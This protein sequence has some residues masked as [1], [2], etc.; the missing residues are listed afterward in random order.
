MKSSVIFALLVFTTLSWSAVQEKNVDFT[1]SPA[2]MLDGEIQYA[3]DWLSPD[4]LVNR[5]LRVITG[6]PIAAKKPSNTQ[7]VISKVAFVAKKSFDKLSPSNMNSEEFISDMLSSVS[8]QEKPNNIWRVTNKV[9][10]YSIPF[11]VGFDLK[12]KEAAKVS[13]SSDAIRYF[14]DE[15]YAFKNNARERFLIV[16]MTNFSQL[17]YRNYS[18]VYVKEISANETLIVSGLIAEF[19]LS[20]ANAFFN[21]PPFSSTRSTMVG[22]LRTQILSMARSLQN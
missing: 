8:I 3:L 17:M 6:E 18:V 9:K 13:L 14:K 19:D 1:L 15:S 21:Y 2:L 12:I 16:D 10:A 11:K 5:N 7:L 20:A 22:N 4:E